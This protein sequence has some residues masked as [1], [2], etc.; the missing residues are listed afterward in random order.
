[1]HCASS[2]EQSRNFQQEKEQEERDRKNTRGLRSVTALQLL[3]QAD[4]R[5]PLL[6]ARDVLAAIPDWL[7]LRRRCL[8]E[9]AGPGGSG[10]SQIALSLCFDLVKNTPGSKALYVSLK[11]KSSMD[12]ALVR[13]SRMSSSDDKSYLKHITV[14]SCPQ[15]DEFWLMMR[16]ELPTLLDNGSYS[17][18]V[19]D[20]IADMFR[21]PSEDSTVSPAFSR[22][23][24]VLAAAAELLRLADNH[25]LAA[26][27]INQLS[28]SEPALGLAWRHCVHNTFMLSESRNISLKK[29][30]E[31]STDV[32]AKYE[33]ASDGVYLAS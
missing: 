6:R 26:I 24:N 11:G 19:L 13:L 1:M 21:L 14:K 30:L 25:N 28:F 10:K 20:S 4:D 15:T 5:I 7:Y 29:S 23:M 27:V 22:A 17:V 31:H 12:K 3:K 18:L 32:R 8:H 9:I 33:I 16:T 2:Y